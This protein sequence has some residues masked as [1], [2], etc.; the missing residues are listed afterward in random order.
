MVAVDLSTERR[1]GA[2][3]S[4]RRKGNILVSWLTSTDHKVI[5]YLYLVT[6]FFYF[7]VGGVMAL[8]MRAQLFAPGLAVVQTREQYNELFTI[9]GTIMLLLFATPLFAGFTNVVMPL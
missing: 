2:T 6:T 1:P 4:A 9:H 8:V 5:G 7:C 3:R